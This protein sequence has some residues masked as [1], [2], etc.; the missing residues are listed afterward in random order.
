MSS[1]SRINSTSSSCPDVGVS[2]GQSYEESVA[3]VPT[4]PQHPE[5]I[6]TKAKATTTESVS[7]DLAGSH[8]PS[9]LIG[10]SYPIGKLQQSI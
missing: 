2:P 10:G 9:H 4:S 6:G 3:G 1:K 5:V 8:R 7:N